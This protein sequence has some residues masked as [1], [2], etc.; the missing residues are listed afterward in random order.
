MA[1]KAKFDGPGGTS[2]TQIA[3]TSRGRLG[4]ARLNSNEVRV[5]IEPSSDEA[6]KKMSGN[7]K[8]WKQP[9]G[10]N[11]RF[12]TIVNGKEVEKTVK[13]GKKLIGSDTSMTAKAALAG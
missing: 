11:R 3:K 13:L 8:D 1:K 4:V 2:Y 7:L 9:E 6:A 12:S 10:K 5:R